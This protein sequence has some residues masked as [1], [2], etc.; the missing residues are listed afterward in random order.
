MSNKETLSQRQNTRVRLK[1]VN[2]GQMAEYFDSIKGYNACEAYSES[3]AMVITDQIQK[4]EDMADL[5]LSVADCYG[6]GKRAVAL[7]IFAVAF[8][9]GRD[10]EIREMAKAMREGK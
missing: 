8:Q 1:D 10:F 5:V 7:T 3:Q 6:L 2:A 4:S 9:L